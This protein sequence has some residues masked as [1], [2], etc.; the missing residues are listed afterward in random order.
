MAVNTIVIPVSRRA[1]YDV[2]S[3]P[4]AYSR[5][6]VGPRQVVAADEDFPQP[7]SSFV[8]EEGVGPVEAHDETE[9][10]DVDPAERVAL[11]AK[12]RPFG[13]VA[14]I[15]IDLATVDGGTRVTMRE[16]P[17]AGLWSRI[18]NPLFDRV[19]W[20]RNVIALRRLRDLVVARSSDTLDPSP[21]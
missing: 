14:D 16:E 18:W 20:A 21:P 1:V 10:R 7:G 8:H 9:V 17:V 3:D 6:V 4:Y 13:A 5:W 19:L 12:L 15:T 11:R 2:L